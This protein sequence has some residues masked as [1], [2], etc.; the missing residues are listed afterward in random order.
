MTRRLI[1]VTAGLSQPSST[2]LL[3]DR[4]AD[5]VIAAIG[6]RGEA[7]DVEVVELRDLAGDLATM[8]TTQIPTPALAEVRERVSRA[9]GLVA[10]TP[11]FTASYSG[12]FKMFFDALDAD[13]VRGMPTII[14]ATAGSARHS[15]VLDHAMRPLFAFLGAVVVPTG[16]FAATED[17]GSGESTGEEGLS[18]RIR[19]A[20]DEL[21]A[22]I[23]ADTGGVDG[24]VPTSTTRPRRSGNTVPGVS[25]GT[26]GSAFEVLLQP[27]LK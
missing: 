19:R 18:G 17:F 10:V 15:L 12:L 22:L 8:M 20:A 13:A 11:V 24:F 16:I 4:I 7:V 2:R 9:D 23:V 5:A 1:V 3:S 25:M 21:A 27:H 26:G 14:A 6:A